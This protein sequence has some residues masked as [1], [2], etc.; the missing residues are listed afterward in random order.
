[1]K[2]CTG[3]RSAMTPGLAAPRL[4]AHSAAARV[5][6]A[7]RVGGFFC[8]EFVRGVRAMTEMPRALD[9]FSH[10]AQAR[11]RGGVSAPP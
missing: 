3:A 8:L 7:P 10:E 1:M 5:T 9:C 6:S 4:Q 2:G 11:R